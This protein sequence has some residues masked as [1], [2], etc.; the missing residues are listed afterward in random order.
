MR[1]PSDSL[2]TIQFLPEQLPPEVQVYALAH[3]AVA[4]ARRFEREHGKTLLA[5]LRA[6]RHD[7]LIKQLQPV[8]AL[9]RARLVLGPDDPV[10]QLAAALRRCPDDEEALIA[11]GEEL[12][13]AL[14]GA[15]DALAAWQ[16]MQKTEG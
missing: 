12:I 16:A 7:L 5:R 14:A 1:I 11:A 9:L 3:A 15:R 6:D 2:R 4:V 8:L 13:A 10:P